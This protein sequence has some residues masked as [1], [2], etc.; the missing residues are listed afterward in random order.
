MRSTPTEAERVLWRML[1]AKRLAEW[2][3]KR[4]QPI[5]R[6][7]VDFVCFQARLIVEADGSQ[8]IG[9]S[10]DGARDGW[11]RDQGFRILRF[12]NNDVLARPDSIGAA[13]FHA[14]KGGE[15]GIEPTSPPTPL[16]GPPPQGGREKKD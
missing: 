14:L 7:I 16:P 4:Q 5:G 12:W 9:S 3:F 15:I 13:I 6:Y 10:Y 11:L 1:R 2:K 8:H